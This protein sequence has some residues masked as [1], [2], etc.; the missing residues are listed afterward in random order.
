MPSTRGTLSAGSNYTISLA[1]NNA[2]LTITPATLTVTADSE[3]KTYGQDDPT[4]TYSVNGFRFSDTT[5]LLTGDLSRDVGE[6]VGS[7]A[8]NAGTLSAGSNYTI[9]LAANNAALT[10]TPATLTVTADSE[11][12]TYGQDDP[13]LAY[14][15]NGF[16]FSDTDALLTGDLS[17]VTGENVGSYAIN[18][19]TLSAGSNYT[20]SLASNNAALTI[21]RSD[22]DRDGRQ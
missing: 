16:Q 21:T 11:T 12:K 1:A 9:S 6:N 20:I 5:A 18:A 10:I 13:T 19:G 8:I 17:R 2:A 7:Y 14:S 3:T 22:A 15:V 4:L